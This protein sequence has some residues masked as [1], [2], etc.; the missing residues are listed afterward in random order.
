MLALPLVIRKT[1]K[2]ALITGSVFGKSLV[3]VIGED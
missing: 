2:Q 3:S 1:K